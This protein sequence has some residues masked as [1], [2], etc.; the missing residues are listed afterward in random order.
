MGSRKKGPT[1][2]PARIPSVPEIQSEPDRLRPVVKRPVLLA[3]SA[4]L[5]SLWIAW[6]IF[7]AIRLG[8]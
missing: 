3:A 2:A 1:P 6:L 8:N 5:F 7:L 4:V